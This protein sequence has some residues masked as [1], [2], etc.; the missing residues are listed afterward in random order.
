M[1]GIYRLRAELTAPVGSE[2]EKLKKS[3]WSIV[4]TVSIVGETL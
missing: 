1:N 4:N 2:K 3:S